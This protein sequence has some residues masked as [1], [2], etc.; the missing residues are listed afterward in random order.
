VQLHYGTLHL[1]LN[2][3]R[4]PP[5]CTMEDKMFT[6]FRSGMWRLYY[7]L[8]NEGR[9][10]FFNEFF[11]LL[12]DTKYTITSVHQIDIRTEVLAE[13]EPKSWYLVY[14]GT[15]VDSRGKG[16]ARKLVEHITLQVNSLSMP[17]GMMLMRRLIPRACQPTLNPHILKTVLST[18]NWAFTMSRRFT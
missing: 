18:R 7:K 9:M 12:N 2:N 11:P 3:G 1:I 17:K 5:G 10:R 15:K 6:L 8:S 14:L 16:Y 4:M 13:R